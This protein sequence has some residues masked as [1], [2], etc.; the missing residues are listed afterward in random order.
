[1]SKFATAF[2]I[3]TLLG[4]SVPAAEDAKKPGTPATD[5]G[6][7][8][9]ETKIRPLLV[10]HCNDCHGED[11]QESALR[12][13]S[14][15]GILTG[16]KAGPVIVPGK[17]KSSLLLTAVGYQDN[18]L[19]MP[20]D[21]KLSDR[22]IQDL[23]RWIE[24]GAPHPDSGTVKVTQPRNQIDIEAGRKHWAF[25]PL[26]QPAVPT[27]DTPTKN[28]IDAFINARLQKN[29]LRPLAA[30]DKRTL[31]R[32][33]TFDLT[34]LPPTPAE[35]DAFLADDSDDAFARLVDRL[36]SS[37]HYGERWGRHWLDVARYADSNGLDENVAHGNA[38]RYRDYVVNAFNNDKPYDKFVIEQLAG[39]LLD[40]GD[41]WKLRHERLIATGYLVLGPKVLAEVDKAK[42][43]MDIVDEQL[44]TVGRS[45][46]G[47]T[48]G[49]A[50]CHTHKFDPIGHDDYYALAGIFKSTRTMETFKTV[51]KWYENE[52][53]TPEELARQKEHEQSVAEK[54][55]TIETLVATAK[56]EL[57]PPMGETVPK[58]VEKRFPEKTQAELK[59][60]REEL[61]TLETNAPKPSTAMGVTEGEVADTS[62]H[63]RGSHLTLG[64]V[65]PRRFPRVLAGDEQPPIPE[66]RSGRLAFARWL[67]DRNPLTARVMVNRIWRWH[68]GRGLVETVDNFGLQGEPPT[69]PELLDWLAIRFIESGWSIKTMHRLIMSSD[70]YQRQSGFDD[71]NVAV[72]VGN[73]FYWRFDV[74]RLDAEAI[75]DALLAV[76][77]TLDPTIGGSLLQHKNHEFVFNHT[78]QDKSEYLSIR[79][80]SIYVPVIRNHLYDMF[81]L[82]DYTDASVLNGNRETSTIAPQALFLMNS[83]LVDELTTAMAKRLLDEEPTDTDRIGRLFTLAYGRPATDAEATRSRQFLTQFQSLLPEQTDEATTHAW[84]ALCQAIVSSSEFIYV[85]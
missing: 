81:Q 40:S 52:I 37:P 28:P 39:D 24:M 65:V 12:L 73:Q 33:A 41:D 83:E 46:M 13:D 21:D 74:Q 23:T 64:D 59:K 61:K 17:P 80:R 67:T 69:H 38:W 42:M 30:A 35:I 26:A 5:E 50:R 9:F 77:G 60:L 51:A 82:F 18:D 7:R 56:S 29:D 49:C 11:L 43:E 19:K 27:L 78:S 15:Q 72:D 1:M 8:F 6:I 2:V 34:G 66:G 14:L 58:D 85:R 36:L 55:Q 71:H 3:L 76:T 31:I 32:R 57:K 62:I 45:L 48:L 16:G 63:L 20:P 68:F 25:Q 44:D 22:Q 84:Q 4:G 79:R 54:K 75:R 53:S 47:L 10:E 70:A